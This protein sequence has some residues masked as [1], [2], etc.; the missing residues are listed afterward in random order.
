MDTEK[1]DH[2]CQ[3]CG[4]PYY[5]CESEAERTDLFGCIACEMDIDM[6]RFNGKAIY[7]PQGKAGEYSNWG[8]NFYVVVLTCANTATAKRVFLQR[9]WVWIILN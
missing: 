4:R 6:K 1:G 8:C 7:N 5:K 3:E 2:I 9:S